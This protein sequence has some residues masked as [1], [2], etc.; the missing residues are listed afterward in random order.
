MKQTI[1][2]GDAIKDHQCAAPP[3]FWETPLPSAIDTTH[4]C[5][6]ARELQARAPHGSKPRLLLFRVSDSQQT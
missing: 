6:I 1:D 3:A 2:S 5:S 4:R